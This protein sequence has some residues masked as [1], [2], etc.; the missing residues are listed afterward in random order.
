MSGH[1]LPI[2]QLG[3]VLRKFAPWVKGGARDGE[4]LQLC[5][6]L[7]VERAKLDH[8]DELHHG[9]PNW[10]P[11]ADE[12][13]RFT[14]LAKR[15]G[16]M[17]APQ[18]VAGWRARQAALRTLWEWGPDMLEWLDPYEPSNPASDYIQWRV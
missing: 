5:A 8:E 12:D 9:E 4:L 18:T 7:E 14:A 11:Y 13:S 3:H 6:S 10:C 16:V 15:I 1:L 2:P 17:E